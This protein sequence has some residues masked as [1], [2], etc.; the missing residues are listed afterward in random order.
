MSYPD[1]HLFSGTI[2]QQFNLVG[3]SVPPLL[4]FEMAKII[5]KRIESSLW[6]ETL[7]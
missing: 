6:V 7:D 2:D 5:K 4:T 1:H 3:E